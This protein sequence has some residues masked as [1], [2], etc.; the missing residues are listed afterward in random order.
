MRKAQGGGG[1]ERGSEG[2]RKEVGGRQGGKEEGREGGREDGSEG[3]R[4]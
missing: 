4:E 1:V 2:A 3:G